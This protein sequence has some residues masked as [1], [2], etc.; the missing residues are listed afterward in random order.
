MIKKDIGYDSA[1]TAKVLAHKGT[2]L[3]KD[4]MLIGKAVDFAVEPYACL[5]ALVQLGEFT[6]TH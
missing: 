6:A 1:V 5:N 2:D 3:P 4:G